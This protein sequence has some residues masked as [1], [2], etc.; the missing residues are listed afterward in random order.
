MF[1]LFPL[2]AP[3]V[4]GAPASQFDGAVPS[5]EGSIP[6]RLLSHMSHGCISGQD[7]HLS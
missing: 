2:A 4:F 3:G 7:W 5:S 6:I 1:P